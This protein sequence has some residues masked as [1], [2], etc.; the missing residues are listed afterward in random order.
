MEKKYKS[1]S[2]IRKITCRVETCKLILNEQS[3]KDHLETVH[4]REDS[5]DRREYGMP[6]LS[7]FFKTVSANK[8]MRTRGPGDSS[9]SGH[10]MSEL[11]EQEVDMDLDDQLNEVLL[12]KRDT[13]KDLEMRETFIRTQ[14]RGLEVLQSDLRKSVLVRALRKTLM[15]KRRWRAT[16]MPVLT[17]YQSWEKR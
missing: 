7:T 3:Y 14:R 9:A 17:C 4:P 10:V 15:M 5:K 1:K 2:K 11:E 16:V 8:K 13:R 6:K 12:G